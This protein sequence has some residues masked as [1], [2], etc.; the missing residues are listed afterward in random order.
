MKGFKE[1]KNDYA[2]NMDTIER[3]QNDAG[4]LNRKLIK[5]WADDKRELVLAEENLRVKQSEIALELQ[6]AKDSGELKVTDKM[7]SHLIENDKEIQELRR[8]KSLLLVDIEEKYQVIL[9]YRDMWNASNSIRQSVNNN[10]KN[11]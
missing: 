7:M 10:E 9:Q 1:N 11:Q 4:Y 6:E 5:S 2:L 3:W 8:E